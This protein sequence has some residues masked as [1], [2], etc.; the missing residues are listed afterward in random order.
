MEG[1]IWIFPALI[2]ALVAVGAVLTGVRRR[3]PSRG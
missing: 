3:P 1:I 2:V